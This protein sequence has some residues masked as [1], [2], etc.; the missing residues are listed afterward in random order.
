MEIRR[1]SGNP[2]EEIGH[3]RMLS[4]PLRLAGPFEL[5]IAE[6][7]MNRAVADR[8]KRHHLA[9]AAALRHGVVP[10]DT[11][12]QRTGAEPAGRGRAFSAF[13]G[14]QAGLSA[15]K[16]QFGIRKLS[17]FQPYYSINE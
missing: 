4:Q 5:G 2:A 16:S 6:I 17:K 14:L 3:R 15:E 8:M 1:F 9:P 7:G 10:F 12:A 13:P 11:P